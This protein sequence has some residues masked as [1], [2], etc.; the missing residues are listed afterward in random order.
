MPSILGANTLSGGYQVANSLRFN[1]DDSPRLAKTEDT[2]QSDGKKLTISA[3]C[4]LGSLG[5]TRY[6][7]GTSADGSYSNELGFNANDKFEFFPIG[8]AQNGITT[9]RLFRDTN[10]WYHIVARLDTT[11]GTNSNRIRLYVNGV[12]ETSF[13]SSS[14]PSEDATTE[15]LK[16]GGSTRV[17]DKGSGGNYFDGHLCELAVLDGQSLGP[18]SF[19]EFDEDS[20]TIWKPKNFKNDVTFGNNGFY[21]EF[22]QTGTSANSS[23]LGADT[24]GNDNHMAATNLAAIDQTVDTCTNNFTTWNA[25]ADN[26]DVTLS[27]GNTKVVHGTAL[28]R[29]PVISSFGVSAGKWYWEWEAAGSPT[30]ANME[31]GIVTS[32]LPS[33]IG[34]YLGQSLQNS[35]DFT[36]YVGDGNI[37]MSG[38]TSDS[39]TA[40]AGGDIIG[41]AVDI[42]NTLIYFY[43]N[44]TLVN[45]GGTNFSG[46]TF[47]GGNTEIY[48]SNADRS[49]SASYTASVNFG[50]PNADNA[51]S[52][53]ASDAN[54]YGNF[55]YAPPSGFYSLCTKNIAEF[56]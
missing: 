40:Y 31:V 41:V 22:K 24:S 42:D 5:S 47:N 1:N 17:G 53:S 27:E 20:P 26:L 9:N 7:F 52:S 54:G 23:G 6:F 44:N 13:A 25:I 2:N 16:N 15:F 8:N 35:A 14:Y 55:E 46:M 21:Y 18:D 51:P 33:E 11:Q 12:Q 28:E 4:K 19:G 50:N 3:W 45:S 56:G 37:N 43:K 29:R 36:T 30:A 49:G 10:A 38:S 32:S 34:R 48:M 39:G